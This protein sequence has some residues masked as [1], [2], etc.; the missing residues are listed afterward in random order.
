MKEELWEK[1]LLW[2][3]GLALREVGGS[4]PTQAR[5]RDFK[6]K[7]PSNKCMTKSYNDH[8]VY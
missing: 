3:M 7:I 8:N 4:N 1:P 2:L 5:K 6:K